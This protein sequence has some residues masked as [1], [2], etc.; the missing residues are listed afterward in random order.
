MPRGG[1]PG[2]GGQHGITPAPEQTGALLLTGAQRALRRCRAYSKARHVL[3][4]DQ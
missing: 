3:S 1:A 4:T 2:L